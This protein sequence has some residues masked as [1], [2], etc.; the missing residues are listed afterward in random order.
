MALFPVVTYM[1]VWLATLVYFI[2]VVHQ[3]L[4]IVI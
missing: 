3:P 2:Q 4:W 1:S